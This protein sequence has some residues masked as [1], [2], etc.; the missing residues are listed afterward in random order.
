[1]ELPCAYC[2]NPV[3]VTCAPTVYPLPSKSSTEHY[4]LLRSRD[5]P[6]LV[7]QLPY[8]TMNAP[9]DALLV[10]R[11]S[12]H[13]VW[14]IVC[15]RYNLVHKECTTTSRCP[16]DN[17]RCFYLSLSGESN[18]IWSQAYEDFRMYRRSSL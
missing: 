7:W 13:G 9:E 15:A 4:R 14:S 2:L 6:V 5:F 16:L 3:F 11:E 8:A 18:P 12:E 17:I 1:M 10:Y